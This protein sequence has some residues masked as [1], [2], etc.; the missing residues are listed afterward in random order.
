MARVYAVVFG[1]LGLCTALIR[2]VIHGVNPQEALLRGWLVLLA[3]SGIGAL[4]GF[5]AEQ[6]LREAVEQRLRSELSN[7]IQTGSENG[8]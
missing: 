3:F 4:L 1:T 7:R 8:T 5:I 6:V 2:D